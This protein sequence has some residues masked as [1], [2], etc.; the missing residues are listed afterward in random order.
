M[1]KILPFLILLLS[2]SCGAVWPVPLSVSAQLQSQWRQSTGLDLAMAGVLLLQRWADAKYQGQHVC[3]C[4]FLEAS[5]ETLTSHNG[6]ILVCFFFF[7][8]PSCLLCS[9]PQLHLS[10]T[11]SFLRFSPPLPGLSGNN[12]NRPSLCGWRGTPPQSK[13]QIPSS[14]WLF[15]VH[16]IPINSV[17]RGFPGS[18]G[19]KTPHFHCRGLEFDF[20][21]GN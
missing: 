12:W 1:L 3:E 13:K 4:C 16:K 21:S 7:G 6:Y 14:M 10:P 20:W 11:P 5:C 17:S 8:H 9:P 2:V 19:V 15:T 18:P